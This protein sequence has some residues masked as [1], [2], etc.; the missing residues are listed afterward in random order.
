MGRRAPPFLRCSQK[1]VAMLQ[2][3]HDPLAGRLLTLRGQ[4]VI[5]DADLANLYGTTTKAFN[6]AIKRNASRFPADFGFQL[7]MAEANALRSQVVTLNARPAR[8]AVNLKSQ[9]VTSSSAHGGVR[10][11]PWAFTEHGAVMAANVLRSPKAVQMSVYVVRAFVAQR[12]A[13]ATNQ[14]VLRRLAE[15]DKTL[16]EHDAALRTLWSRLKPLLAP[17]LDSSRKEMGFHVGLRKAKSRR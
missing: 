1:L 14:A 15:I 8:V 16:F 17:P 10:K 5:L 13:L 6:Q 11:L 2:P 9:F 7:T 12:E 4:R 3:K